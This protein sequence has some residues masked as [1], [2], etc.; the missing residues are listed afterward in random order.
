LLKK[1]GPFKPHPIF[2]DR[3]EAS[4][5]IRPRRNGISPDLIAL[6]GQIHDEA[7]LVLGLDFG[8]SCVKAVIR[9][10][11]SGRAFAVPFT[12]SPE[13][14]YLL[15]SRVWLT[16]GVYSLDGGVD[17]REDLKLRLLGCGVPFPVDEFNDSCAL[18]ALVIRHCRG[19]LLDSHAS[20][21][22]HKRIQ[23]SVNIG[24]PSRS[25]E[26]DSR[27]RL[28][29]RLAWAAANVACH[30]VAQVTQELCELYR[31]Q[32]TNLYQSKGDGIGAQLEFRPEDVDVIPEIAAQIYGLVSVTNW[33]WR[34][35]PMVM[36][37]D[38]G[39][40][41]VDTAFFSFTR[42]IAGEPRFAFYATDVQPS[43]VM[44]L[45]RRRIDWLF[46]AGGDHGSDPAIQDYLR[47]IRLPTT[48]SSIPEAV[49]EYVP[50]YEI[51]LRSGALDV[52]ADFYWS[53]FHRQVAICPQHARING[54]IP[55]VQ[56]SRIPCFLAGGGSRMELYSKV[57]ADVNRLPRN[58]RLEKLRMTLPGAS[59][60]CPGL[61]E[62]DM[63]RV[64]VAFGLSHHGAGGKPLGKLVRSIDIPK[65]DSSDAHHSWRESYVDKDRC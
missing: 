65:G 38:I 29:R 48:L 53:R 21:Y 47:R 13:S 23:W 19:W 49:S 57:I 51:V 40:G 64:S 25:Y 24:L 12:S 33:D 61:R 31:T 44:N 56:L 54:G 30:H 6:G 17:I 50:G 59:L 16:N 2:L 32:T 18:L 5:R 62:S 7:D 14:T 1:V 34:N 58:I 60:V 20:E 11:L 8:T 26:D 42:A 45:H 46:Q 55:D 3:R 41:T 27:V 15:P 36:L 9:D 43:G 28:F 52:D 10:H 39:A 63:D 22:R 37:V 4:E 35:R